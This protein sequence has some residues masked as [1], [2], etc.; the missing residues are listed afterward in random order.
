MQ[1]DN[2]TFLMNISNGQKNPFTPYQGKKRCFGEY[3]CQRCMKT[4]KSANS[5]ANEPQVCTNCHASVYAM[6]QKSLQSMYEVLRKDKPMKIALI[7]AEQK[8]QVQ[9]ERTFANWPICNTHNEL[10]H[11]IIEANY[12]RRITKAWHY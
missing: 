5:R 11:S 10:A 7:E 12:S 6:K 2:N 9:P 3:R 8:K 4:W 1:S